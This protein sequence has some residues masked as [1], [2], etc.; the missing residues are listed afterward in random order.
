MPLYVLSGTV[1]F[2]LTALVCL[3]FYIFLYSAIILRHTT[4]DRTPLD[5]LSAYRVDLYLNTLHSQETNTHAPDG[6]RTHNPSKRA[7]SDPR[8]RLR[9]HCDRGDVLK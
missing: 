4:L 3:G 6:I 5:K 1:F 7:A 9:V 8:L 2:G